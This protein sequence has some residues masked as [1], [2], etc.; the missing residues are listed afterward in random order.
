MFERGLRDERGSAPLHGAMGEGGCTPDLMRIL[1]GHITHHFSLKPM[2]LSVLEELYEFVRQDQGVWAPLQPRGAPAPPPSSLA[3]VSVV[4]DVIVVVGGFNTL[5]EADL[6][7]LHALE[8]A[9]TSG[10]LT[11]RGHAE[12]RGSLASDELVDEGAASRLRA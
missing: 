12:A 3:A 8:L 11:K 1:L 7:A 5:A 10:L 9:P 6:H 4:R 2:F